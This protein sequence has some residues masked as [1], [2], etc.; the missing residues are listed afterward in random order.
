MGKQMRQE[1]LLMKHSRL[2]PS[3]SNYFE[4]CK[5]KAYNIGQRLLV[6]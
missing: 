2:F 6:K 5:A 1:Y 4:N 3:F